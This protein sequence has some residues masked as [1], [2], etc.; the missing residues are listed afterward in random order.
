MGGSLDIDL[1]D[2][3]GRIFGRVLPDGSLE[4]GT[5]DAALSRYLQFLF[6]EFARTLNVTKSAT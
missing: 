1:D 2:E 4:A 5:R 3:D 6:S